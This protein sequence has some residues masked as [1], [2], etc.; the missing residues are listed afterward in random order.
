MGT[1]IFKKAVSQFVSLPRARRLRAVR[2][3]RP[4]LPPRAGSDYLTLQGMRVVHLIQPGD[5]RERLLSPGTANGGIVYAS[6]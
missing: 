5:R 2:R 6:R 1:E 4:A 3:T